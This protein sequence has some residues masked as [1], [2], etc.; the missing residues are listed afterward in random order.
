MRVEGLHQ[1]A[2][3]VEDMDRAEAFYRDVLGLRWVARFDPPGLLFFDLGN[4]RL[5]LEAGAPPSLLYLQVPDIDEAWA[6][7]EAKG[8]V[9]RGRPAR[10]LPGRGR[11]LRSGR[12][13]GV[14]GLLPRQRG[15]P[16][17]ARRDEAHSWP[18]GVGELAGGRH[19]AAVGAHQRLAERH[20]LPP[21]GEPSVGDRVLADDRAQVLHAHVQREHH[22]DLVVHAGHR[23]HHRRCR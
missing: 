22:R 6:E 23:G 11:H 8:V 10:D 1:V 18:D 15:Q 21:A 7:L 2:L 3:H 19:L 9:A 16:R 14:D 12:R 20:R 4:V 17:R 13:R 5:L